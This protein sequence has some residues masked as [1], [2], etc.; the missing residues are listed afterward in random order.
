MSSSAGE[1]R[2]QRCI[3]TH[4]HTCANL[5]DRQHLWACSIKV[6]DLLSGSRGLLLKFLSSWRSPPPPGNSIITRSP[7]V[8]PPTAT[9]STM[10]CKRARIWHFFCFRSDD[11]RLASSLS[12]VASLGEHLSAML[13]C[14]FTDMQ[15]CY[16]HPSYAPRSRNTGTSCIRL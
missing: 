6:I 7:C 12:I 5:R 10:T 15:R 11:F 9:V 14:H 2:H 4:T 3:H 13:Q 16:L 1:L 8:P